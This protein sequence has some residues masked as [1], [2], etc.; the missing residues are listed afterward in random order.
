MEILKLFN[1][2]L[3]EIQILEIKVFLA[4]YFAQQTTRKMDEFYDNQG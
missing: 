1:Y 4:E 2:N 3:S